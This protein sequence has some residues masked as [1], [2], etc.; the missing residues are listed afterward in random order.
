MMEH[1]VFAAIN[2]ACFVGTGLLL[3]LLEPLFDMWFRRKAGRRHP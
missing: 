1:A 3:R 2:V